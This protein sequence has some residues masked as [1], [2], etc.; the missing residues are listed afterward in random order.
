M[1]KLWWTHHRIGDAMHV[2]T[3][4]FSHFSILTEASNAN[5]F[6]AD[7]D[8]GK[9]HILLVL[10]CFIN[11]NQAKKNL[12]DHKIIN[13]SGWNLEDSISDFLNETNNLHSTR[14]A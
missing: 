1:N 10:F 7:G 13:S 11:C 14:G 3:E 12:F 2:E 6:L 5:I 4:F 9:S 8:L